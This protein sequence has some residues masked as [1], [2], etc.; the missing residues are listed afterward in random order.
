MK[1]SVRITGLDIET[2]AMKKAE[3]YFKQNGV[4]EELWIAVN[5]ISPFK[6]PIEGKIEVA[7]TVFPSTAATPR[8]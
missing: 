7:T 8:G 5:D 6:T 4:L 1:V 2:G 3:E